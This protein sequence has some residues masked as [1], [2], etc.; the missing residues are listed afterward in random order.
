MQKYEDELKNILSEVTTC[1]TYFGEFY[2][3][4]EIKIDPKKMPIIYIDF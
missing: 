2:S 1:E 3:L 4:N